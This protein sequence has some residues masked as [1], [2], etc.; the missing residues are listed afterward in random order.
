V[1]D[2]RGDGSAQRA[3]DERLNGLLDRGTGRGS[4]RVLVDP[5]DPA[6]AEMSLFPQPL[7]APPG[8]GR[9]GAATNGAAVRSIV[10]YASC[11]GNR[12]RAAR[13]SVFRPPS[14][15]A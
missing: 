14:P 8:R 2:E 13:V 9:V 6:A 12:F 15:I 10:P 7:G 5:V 4:R 1:G 11:P 3:I